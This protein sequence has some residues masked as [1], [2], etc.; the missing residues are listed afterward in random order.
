MFTFAT[1]TMIG[2]VG[3]APLIDL[4]GFSTTVVVPVAGLLLA[5]IIAARD[6]HLREIPLGGAGAVAAPRM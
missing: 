1:G 4:V 5:G 2:S 3:V 6:R